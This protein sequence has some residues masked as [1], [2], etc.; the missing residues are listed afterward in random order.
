MTNQLII[1]TIYD[2]PKD[3]SSGFIARKFILDKPTQEILTAGTLDAVRLAVQ[4][5]ETYELTKIARSYNDDPCIIESW[6]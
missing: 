4:N 6:L 5:A 1:W 3:F 2:H